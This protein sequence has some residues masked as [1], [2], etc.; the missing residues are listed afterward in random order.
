VGNGGGLIV[1]L[2]G[3]TGDENVMW[4]F[5]GKLPRDAWI[6]SP[7]GTVPAPSGYGWTANRQGI[8]TPIE[9][10]APACDALER[11]ID[12]WSSA[13]NISPTPVSL[14]GFSQGAAL[15]Y[16]F[17]LIKPQKVGKIAGLAGFLPAGAERN[18]ESLPLHGKRVFVA[19]GSRDETVPLQ[20]AEQ[21]IAG[22]ERAG[23]AV[24]TCV[25]TTGHKLSADCMRGLG[26]FFSARG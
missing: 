6:I 15:A 3:W 11:L 24:K 23:A 25:S 19:H 2:H 13:Q 20:S 18:F 4:V 16:S 5:A 8:D 12:A 1:L 22:L 14:V 21:A 10:F 17:A 9:Q 7:R 26:E